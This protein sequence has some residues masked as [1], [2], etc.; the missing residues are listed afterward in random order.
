M[1][2]AVMYYGWICGKIEDRAWLTGMGF[3]VGRYDAPTMT[4]ADCAGTEAAKR[5]L[6]LERKT[7]NVPRCYG[8]G[9]KK[10]EHQ[11]EV[12]AAEEILFSAVK[13]SVASPTGA[14]SAEPSPVVEPVPAVIVPLVKKRRGRTPLP[15]KGFINRSLF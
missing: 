6:D 10:P 5:K 2:D 8:L 3:K 12:E 9:L 1:A 4:F 15:T 13:S 7:Y 11:E 14:T